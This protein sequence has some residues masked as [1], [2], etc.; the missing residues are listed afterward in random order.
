MKF[1]GS[2]CRHRFLPPTPTP[3]RHLSHSF[4]GPLILILIL[5]STPPC[6]LFTTMG[7]QAHFPYISC[8]SP[9]PQGLYLRRICSPWRLPPWR[10]SVSAICERLR[11][12]QGHGF[13]SMGSGKF[14]E[15]GQHYCDHAAST[16]YGDVLG[17][18]RSKIFT[19]DLIL[20]P[21]ESSHS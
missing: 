2:P 20:S 14:F 9:V 5:L 1:H 3:I 8:I 19:F 15:P 18:F 11:R 6:I 21:M 10:I 4:S 7:M 17:L 13:E 16:V 12:L